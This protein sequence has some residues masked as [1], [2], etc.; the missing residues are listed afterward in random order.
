VE[1]DNP[2]DDTRELVP[3]LQIRACSEEIE[4][5]GEMIQVLV[6]ITAVKNLKSIR[7]LFYASHATGA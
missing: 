5:D 7:R 3:H 6:P 2:P 1:W 4:E